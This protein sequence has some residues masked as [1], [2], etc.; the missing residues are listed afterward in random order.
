MVGKEFLDDDYAYMLEVIAK[1]DY[2]LMGKKQKDFINMF[3][4]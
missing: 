1:N 4:I 3:N 2:T